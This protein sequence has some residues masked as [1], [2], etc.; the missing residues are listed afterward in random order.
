[1]H[2]IKSWSLNDFG[3]I[4]SATIDL[5]N[6]GGM[7]SLI[8]RNNDSDSAQSNGSGKS[9]I[10]NGLYWILYG[11]T[12]DKRPKTAIVRERAKGCSGI[13]EFENL[14]V[15]RS[16]G[17]SNALNVW[18]DGA[19]VA[20]TAQEKQHRIESELGL[21]S[22]SFRNTVLYGQRD[23]GR[24]ISPLVK[25]TEKK[26]I[27]SLLLGH[28]KY[29]VARERAK[30][31]LKELSKLKAEYEEK[32]SRLS[33]EL[34]SK[35]KEELS[36]KDAL[37]ETKLPERCCL[38]LSELKTQL[39]TTMSKFSELKEEHSLAFDDYQ[40]V[41]NKHEA[42]EKEKSERRLNQISELKAKL[43]SIKNRADEITEEKP[44][45]CE[46]CGH[47]NNDKSK[48]AEKLDSLRSQYKVLKLEL[49]TLQ[50]IKPAKEPTTI[51]KQKFRVDLLSQELDKAKLF[52]SSL[53]GDIKSAEK[54]EE[55]VSMM[56]EQVES[57]RK[58]QKDRIKKI[59]LEI[60]RKK[61]ELTCFDNELK[62]VKEEIPY[63][64][65]WVFAYGP[66]GIPSM[67]LDSAVSYLTKKTNEFLQVLTDGDISLDFKTQ[68][69]KGS[70]SL[71]INWMVEGAE[72][73]QPSGGQW[74]K[75]EIAVDLALAFLAE[76]TSGKSVNLLCLDECLDGLDDPGKQ[77]VCDLLYSIRDKRQNII[78]VSHDEKVRELFEKQ[79]IVTK[80]GG[81]SS[82]KIEY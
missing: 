66:K 27:L 74:R 29:E 14:K 9:T 62:S 60:D 20:G 70:E 41:K 80:K 55:L 7:M 68:N 37:S 15:E 6:H 18:I 56:K 73:K 46:N 28:E 81:K 2:N 58:V 42:E 67:Q 32:I 52:I 22:V 36:A 61:E 71:T 45:V 69:E 23:A 26:R 30:E 17:K 8:G 1:M 38:D 47:T 57:Q 35:R 78:V 49:D 63:Y 4:S 3:V 10:F 21:D 64:D 59:A 19:E 11:D 72:N 25:D 16:R 5:E 44:V 24:F 40:A 79:I 31:K 34:E 48:K 13:V 65:Y 33:F 39:D 51:A 76:E 77:R 43:S 82:V 75:I 53:Q 12:L 50:K 54:E